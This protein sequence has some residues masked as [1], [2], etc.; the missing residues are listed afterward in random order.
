MPTGY[1]SIL[2][3]KDDVTFNEFVWRCARGMGA[4]IML[5]DDHLG[6]ALPE[7]LPTTD[8][9]HVHRLAEARTKLGELKNMSRADAQER[10]AQAYAKD[11]QDKE[12]H[13]IAV[14]AVRARLDA[15][16]AQVVAW[17]PPGTDHNGLKDFMLQ[18][19]DETIRF[20][21][22][23]SDYFLNIKERTGEEWLQC[24]IEH[25]KRDIDYHTR[26]LAASQVRDADR[27][28]WVDDLRQSVPYVRPRD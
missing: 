13:I 1:T 10:A 16:R 15:M 2:C 5:R 12:R 17:S 18:Q 19:L 4:L 23:V 24:S 14:T 8:D 3:D 21:G 22:R 6:A 26:E 9:Y 25:A 7:K 27:Q 11:V 20:D 28:K